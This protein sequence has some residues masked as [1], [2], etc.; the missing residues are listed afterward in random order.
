MLLCCA[1]HPCFQAYMNHLPIYC[2][3]DVFIITEIHTFLPKHV[4][5]D[6]ESRT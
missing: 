6:R 2:D 4:P 5:K 3:M 1:S